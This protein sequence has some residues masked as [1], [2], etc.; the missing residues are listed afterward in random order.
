MSEGRWPRGVTPRQWSGQLLRVP[1]CNGAGIAEKSYPTTRS[2]A[3]A[4]RSY[5]VSRVRGG[6]WEELPQARGERRRPGGPTPCPR[7]RGCAGAGGPTG[8]IPR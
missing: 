8:A 3:A 2:G 7:G 6:G 5:P 1:G 4:E